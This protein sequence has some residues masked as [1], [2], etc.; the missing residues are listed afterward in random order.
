MRWDVPDGRRVF[1][2]KLQLNWDERKK[3][4]TRSGGGKSSPSGENPM[5]KG[6]AAGR[7]LTVEELK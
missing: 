2:R 5:D 1:Q 3:E 4:L 6:C 7:N